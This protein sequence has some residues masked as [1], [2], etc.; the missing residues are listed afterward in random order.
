[1]MPKKLAAGVGDVPTPRL[2]REEQIEFM[3]RAEERVT[4]YSRRWLSDP[5]F[6]RSLHR[7]DPKGPGGGPC[8]CRH[9]EP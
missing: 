6:K 3:E 4:G 5:E 8:D 2:S 7:Y 1:M 9:A